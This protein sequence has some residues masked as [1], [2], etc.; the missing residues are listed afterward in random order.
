MIPGP[1]RSLG[2]ENDNPLQY[3]CL[4]N[5]VD[6]GVWRATVHGIQW[7]SPLILLKAVGI[8]EILSGRTIICFIDVLL[9]NNLSFEENDLG[10]KKV[11]ATSV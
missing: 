9:K 1:G 5:P 7:L 2:E 4:G 8:M 6:R 11:I 3:S 10:P